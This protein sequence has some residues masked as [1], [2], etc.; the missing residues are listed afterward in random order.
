MAIVRFTVRATP[1]GTLRPDG[2]LRFLLGAD[3]E[4]P[5][6]HINYERVATFI[7]DKKG[8]WVEPL[9]L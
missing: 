5:T 6:T 9:P 4:A 7:E 2:L 8:A 3:F 1:E